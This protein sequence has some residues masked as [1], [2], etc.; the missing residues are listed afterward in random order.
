MRVNEWLPPAVWMVVI[1]MLSTDYFSPVRTGVF[2]VPLLQ[3][4]LPNA[5]ASLLQALHFTVRK[6]GHMTEYGV[7]ALLWYRA[8]VRPAALTPARAALAAL[9]IAVA[10]AGCDEAFQLMMPLRSARLFDVVVDGVGAAVALAGGLVG[11]RAR[12]GWRVARGTAIG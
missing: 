2:V 6:I 5:S 4:L 11:R 1:L 10:W 9:A 8:F 7:L 12:V 3:D